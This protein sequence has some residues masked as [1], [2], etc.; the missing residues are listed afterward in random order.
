MRAMSC[1][2]Y[3]SGPTVFV[4]QNHAFQGSVGVLVVQLLIG[5][6]SAVVVGRLS[7]VATRGSLEIVSLSCDAFV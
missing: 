6:F 3:L 4:A 2:L 7:F 1:F 5:S